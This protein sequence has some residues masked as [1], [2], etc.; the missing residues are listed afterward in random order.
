[1]TIEHI[2]PRQK[3]VCDLICSG[4]V[5]GIL[6]YRGSR[7]YAGRGRSNNVTREVKALMKRGLVKEHEFG[8]TY[9]LVTFAK[10]FEV[11]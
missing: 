2:T 3:E 4:L 6:Q 8:G 11:E 9:S 7:Y 10:A 1:M 5:R